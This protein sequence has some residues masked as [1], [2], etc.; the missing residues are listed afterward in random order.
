MLDGVGGRRTHKKPVPGTNQAT[1]LT[2]GAYHARSLD[3]C[4]S[5]LVLAAVNPLPSPIHTVQS[6][7]IFPPVSR[8]PTTKP[9]GLDGKPEI[10]R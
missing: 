7:K 9:I 10:L 5:G 1:T 8:A 3:P 4:Y 2:E 6:A